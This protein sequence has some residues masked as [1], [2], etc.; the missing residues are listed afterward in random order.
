MH[1]PHLNVKISPIILTKT[2][3]CGQN[4]YTSLRLDR[5]E[6]RGHTSM[7]L[8]HIPGAE[9]TIASSPYVIQEPALHKPEI[10]TA[11]PRFLASPMI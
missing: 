4:N 10:A 9:E 8:R 2:A 3:V 6:R 5:K 11:L 1:F 7:R